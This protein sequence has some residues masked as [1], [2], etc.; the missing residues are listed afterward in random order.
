MVSGSRPTLGVLNLQNR[1]YVTHKRKNNKG[2]AKELETMS[3]EEMEQD[4]KENL[5]SDRVSQT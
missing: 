3:D 2:K 1:S 5:Y 4:E